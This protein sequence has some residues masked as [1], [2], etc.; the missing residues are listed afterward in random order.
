LLARPKLFPE[1]RRRPRRPVLRSRA[2]SGTKARR[3]REAG[4]RH[5][6]LH[7]NNALNH[8]ARKNNIPRKHKW[9][10]Y[11][12]MSSRTREGARKQSGGCALLRTKPTKTKLKKAIST[13]KCPS[14]KLS[15][16]HVLQSSL[17]HLLHGPV[18]ILERRVKTLFL[19]TTTPPPLPPPFLPCTP[20]LLSRAGDRICGARPHFHFGPS[21]AAKLPPSATPAPPPLPPSRRRLPLFCTVL[22]LFLSAGPPRPCGFGRSKRHGR[23]RRRNTQ[24]RCSRCQNIV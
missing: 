15:C 13:R 22:F 4:A 12:S 21:L 18:P 24:S 9:P 19:T 11:F 1:A 23:R 7:Q 6:H 17:M 3:S 16:C 10:P 14:R 2:G 5:N 8:K 20:P